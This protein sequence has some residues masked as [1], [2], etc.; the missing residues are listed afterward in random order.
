MH[1]KIDPVNRYTRFCILFLQI[2]YLIY[3]LNYSNVL[4]NNNI[5]MILSMVL[6]VTC[7]FLRIITTN[8]R[9]S[10]CMVIA[11][12]GSFWGWICSFINGSGFGSAVTMT[13]VLCS[14]CLFSETSFNTDSWKKIYLR[15]SVILLIILVVFSN[16]NLYRSR[17]YSILPYFPSDLGLNP[18]T[19]AMLSMFLLIYIFQS[20]DFYINNKKIKRAIQIITVI[21]VS[22]NI[23]ITEGRS[24]I[25]TAV[26]FIWCV[27]FLKNKFASK[28][29]K[30][31]L[32]VL[33]ISIIIPIIYVA[34]YNSRF[35]V[36]ETIL[37]KS[38]YSGRESIWSD[39]IGLI[40]DNPIFGSSNK[41]VFSG[42]YLSAH[43]SLLAILC[44]YGVLGFLA[45]TSVCY[46]SFK[47][48]NS[49]RNFISMFAILC[50]VFT[51][52]FE[53]LT[54]DWSLVWPFCFL[55]VKLD[56]EVIKNDTEKNTLLLV[57]R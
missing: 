54:T 23:W 53:T 45:Y 50:L 32:I 51:M 55:F 42:G 56:D 21:F 22:W 36:G 31:Y 26:A 41:T 52:T 38:L 24:S 6:L 3:Y 57:R 17:Y 13:C 33:V 27:I 37:G 16:P 11:F 30:I 14:I 1:I 12:L 28:H 25:V 2:M 15:M 43:N 44:Y 19:V 18:N 35:M 8:G 39:V 46:I 5:L 29:M 34:M 48:L 7:L 47:A 20:I 40:L 9:I 4:F 49:N 10:M